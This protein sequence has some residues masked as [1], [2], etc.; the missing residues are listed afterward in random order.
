MS[1]YTEETLGIYEIRF[2]RHREFPYETVYVEND[3]ELQA[4]L[5]F[6]KRTGT[7]EYEDHDGDICTANVAALMVYHALE[8]WEKEV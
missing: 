5:E 3:G 4:T 6:I 8:L 2:K 7:V 1:I